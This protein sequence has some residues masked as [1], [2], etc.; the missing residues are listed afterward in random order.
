MTLT[1]VR[2]R[3]A[4]RLRVSLVQCGVTTDGLFARGEGCLGE[5]VPVRVL[6]E[7]HEQP[8]KE[9]SMQL[10]SVLVIDGDLRRIQGL[11]QSPNVVENLRLIIRFY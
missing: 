6:V 8:S 5:R 10:R 2:G 11:D 1:E 7:F 9:L 3:S 4:G